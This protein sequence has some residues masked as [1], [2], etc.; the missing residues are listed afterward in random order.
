MLLLSIKL[1]YYKNDWSS[2]NQD[3]QSGHLH[4]FIDV[5]FSNLIV[6][7]NVLTH[8]CVIHD[9]CKQ[10]H[11]YVLYADSDKQQAINLFLGVFKPRS[12]YPD[13]WELP[14]DY[15]LHHTKTTELPPKEQTYR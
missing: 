10:Y 1:L 3:I 8:Y 14:T 2:C 5:K 4:V 15:Y 6:Y 11:L 7:R 9:L 12:G 13:L